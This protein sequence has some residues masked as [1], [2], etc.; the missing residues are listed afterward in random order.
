MGLAGRPEKDLR[1]TCL[2]WGTR[3]R[4]PL[5][6]ILTG[7]PHGGPGTEVS[8]GLPRHRAGTRPARLSALSLTP[9]TSGRPRVLF[10][11]RILPPPL[12][13]CVRW[14]TPSQTSSPN[15]RRPPAPVKGT[16]NTALRPQGPPGCY[17]PETRQTSPA[18]EAETLC[19]HTAPPCSALPHSAVT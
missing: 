19:R 16:H 4:R 13:G 17:S 10:A 12:P 6:A 2:S 15:P 7:G 11:R 1:Q 3:G 8:G 14:R 18:Q 9:E 5:L